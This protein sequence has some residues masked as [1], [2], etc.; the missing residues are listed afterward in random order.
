M[1]QTR[2]VEYAETSLRL[3]DEAERYLEA[4]DLYKACEKGLEAVHG[5]MR[6]VAEPRGWACESQRDLNAV[7]SDLAFETEYISRAISLIGA[8]EGGL[9]IKFWGPDHADWQVEGGIRNAREWI[10]MME[11]RSK[12]PPEVRDSQLERDAQGRRELRKMLEESR[13]KYE[14]DHG[15]SSDR[16]NN[17]A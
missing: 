2:I 4:D 12:P 17:G 15:K 14:R 7:A 1:T 6:A 10:A 5:Y 8:T 9:A 13:A 3:L 16:Y 11:S